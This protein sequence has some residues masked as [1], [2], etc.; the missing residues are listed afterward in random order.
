[1]FCNICGS[2][3]PDIVDFCPNCGADLRAFKQM[4]VSD[5]AAF[6]AAAAGK[7]S[8]SIMDIPIEEAPPEEYD[9]ESGTT[10]LTFDMS[11]PLSSDTGASQTGFGE[12]EAQVANIQDKEAPK[13]FIDPDTPREHQPQA[14]A[15]KV[16]TPA[17]VTGSSILSDSNVQPVTP[18]VPA[19]QF[20][21]NANQYQQ[22]ASNQYQNNQ[23]TYM[24]QQTPNAS[25]QQPQG[26][27]T[28]SS[29]YSGSIPEEYKPIS[30]L[31]YLGYSLL[32]SCVPIAGII[33][34]FINAFGSGKNINVRN[35]ARGILL[36]MLIGVV[37]SVLFMIIFAAMGI[38]LAGA[39]SDY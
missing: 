32:Y 24:Q 21:P 12:V 13:P 36:S 26:M 20:Q 8:D 39:F 19:Q 9:P 4:N 22:G 31:G 14:P 10:V 3:V 7:A 35:Y 34:L 5:T 11:G 37:V 18:V 16:V 28:Q 6:N 25:Y 33:L 17:P 23:N 1:M 38:G 30:P 29:A 2:N 15:D 27:N